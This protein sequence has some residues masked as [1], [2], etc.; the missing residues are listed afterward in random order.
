MN[1]SSWYMFECVMSMSNLVVFEH[2]SSSKQKNK[3]GIY[4]K[5]YCS[6]AVQNDFVSFATSS[7][8]I[9]TQWNFAQ[10]SRIWVSWLT[11][12]SGFLNFS[13]IS[14]DFTVHWEQMSRVQKQLFM[15]R[16]QKCLL[17]P[18]LHG[19]PFFFKKKNFFAVLKILKTNPQY[20]TDVY[21]MG[22][23]FHDEIHW[24][25][26]YTDNTNWWLWTYCSPQKTNDVHFFV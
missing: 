23:I 24:H 10:T 15:G 3:V 6:H 14:F 26:N 20:H 12:K 11:K 1:F 22:A 5:V 21:C 8:D 9:Q 18:G 13:S 4:E 17:L 19:A 2:L 7:S 16:G 25:V